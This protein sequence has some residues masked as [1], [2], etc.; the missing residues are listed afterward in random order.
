MRKIRPGDSV[1]AMQVA[2]LVDRQR[3]DV[4]GV[5]LVEE[6]ALAVGRDPVDVALL[7]GGGEERAVGRGG[8]RPDVLVVGIEERLRRCRRRRPGRSCRRARWRRR[9]RR[10]ARAR[11]RALPSRRRRRRSRSCRRARSSG[12]GLRCRCRPTACRRRRRGASR[13]TAPRSRRPARSPG[14]RKTRPS[15]S[16]ER[17][18]TSPLRKSVCVE[19][20]QKVGV[21]ARAG[22][23]TRRAPRPPPHRY[24]LRIRMSTRT[25]VEIDRQHARAADRRVHRE[26]PFAERGAADGREVAAA[27]I[28][29]EHR[30]APTGAAR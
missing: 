2:A 7:A 22:P 19:T 18:S 29:F 12:P 28:A 26:L 30:R 23:P 15:L 16:I 9:G 20:V 13:G 8:E 10:S 21:E 4:G 1:P 6:R 11:A 25:A 14:P 27:A 3:D 17:F 24:R 5:G